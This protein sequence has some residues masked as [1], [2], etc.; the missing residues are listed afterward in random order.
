M[1]KD[2]NVEKYIKMKDK[3]TLEEYI[4]KNA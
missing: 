2:K 4:K 1:Q 3:G